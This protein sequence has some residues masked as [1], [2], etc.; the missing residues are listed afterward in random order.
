MSK[1]TKLEAVFKTKDYC[2]LGGGLY[3]GNDANV[4]VEITDKSFIV[5]TKK[6]PDFKKT[7]SKDNYGLDIDSEIGFILKENV[8]KIKK[9]EAEISAKEVYTEGTAKK[10]YNQHIRNSKV[11]IT[12]KCEHFLNRQDLKHSLKISKDYLPTSDFDTLIACGSAKS[13]A[14]YRKAVKNGCKILTESELNALFNC[15]WI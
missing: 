9:E 4:S 13:S 15:G 3:L 6:F 2:S 14:K 11:S 8:A 1:T 10:L 5:T 7:L 12:G